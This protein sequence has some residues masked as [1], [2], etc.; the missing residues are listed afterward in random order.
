MQVHFE[1]DD[2]SLSLVKAFAAIAKESDALG[3]TA[4]SEVF[5]GLEVHEDAEPHPV[6]AA[7]RPRSRSRPLAPLPHNDSTLPDRTRR[8][9]TGTAAGIIVGASLVTLLIY[10]LLAS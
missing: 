10:F 9:S 7:A 1:E 3:E 2:P 8:L 5:A 6:H 4:V